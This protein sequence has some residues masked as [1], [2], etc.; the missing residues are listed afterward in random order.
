MVALKIVTVMI[1]EHWWK[2]TEGR[3]EM[4]GEKYVPVPFCPS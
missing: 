3:P 1:M 4:L 2:D